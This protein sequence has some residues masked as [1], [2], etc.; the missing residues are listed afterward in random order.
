MIMQRKRRARN[1]AK[2]IRSENFRNVFQECQNNLWNVANPS[3]HAAKSPPHSPLSQYIR[4][5]IRGGCTKEGE[6]AEGK[7]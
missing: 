1:A 5:H 3:S 6:S 4:I 7:D 2:C